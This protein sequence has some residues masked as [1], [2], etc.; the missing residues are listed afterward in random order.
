MPFIESLEMHFTVYLIILYICF[1]VS[2]LLLK[3][4]LF[5]NIPVKDIFWL[6]SALICYTSAIWYIILLGTDFY[7]PEVCDLNGTECS[8]PKECKR[9]NAL[10]ISGLN[11]SAIIL[12]PMFAGAFTLIL[13]PFYAFRCT[14]CSKKHAFLPI[15]FEPTPVSEMRDLIRRIEKTGPTQ[16][17]TKD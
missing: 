2:M 3:C 14:A 8:Q 17:R 11:M 5:N 16:R 12:G 1:P 10:S 4:F 15:D 9:L 13:E 6:L 7:C